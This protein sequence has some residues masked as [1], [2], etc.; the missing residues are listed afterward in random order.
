MRLDNSLDPDVTVAARLRPGNEEILDYYLLPSIDRLSDNLRL[1]Q[2]NGIVL[3][4]YRFENL[5]FFVRLARRVAIEEA[6]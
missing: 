1:A 3:D 6:L 4:V 5:N 2:D